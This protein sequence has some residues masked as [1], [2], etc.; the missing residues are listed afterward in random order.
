MTGKLYDKHV[1]AIDR[2][3]YLRVKVEGGKVT[4]QWVYVRN[5]EWNG[6]DGAE[7]IGVAESDLKRRGFYYT[8][9]TEMED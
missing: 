4:D 6:N 8:G 7:M 2:N 3:A 1:P 9:T 5:G